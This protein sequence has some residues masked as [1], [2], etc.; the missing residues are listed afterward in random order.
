MVSVLSEYNTQGDGH[1]FRIG[2]VWDT[3]VLNDIKNV[4]AYEL[5]GKKI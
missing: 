5:I 3:S 4:Q 2:S 1:G